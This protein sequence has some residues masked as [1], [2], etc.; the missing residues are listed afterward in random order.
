MSATPDPVELSAPR[1]PAR[2]GRTG[3]GGP[4]GWAI[5]AFGVL[6]VLAGAAIAHFGPELLPAR[7]IHGSAPEPGEALES[8]PPPASFV[9]APPAPP[10]GP[11]QTPPSVGG[12]DVAALSDRLAALEAEA[13][14]T[15]RAAAAALAAAALVEAAQTSR[16]FGEELSALERA[17]GPSLDLSSLD[18]LAQVGAPSRAALSAAFPDY[19]ARAV[20]AS[21]RP[22]DGAGLLDRIG[23]ALSRVVTLRRVGET[24]GSGVDAVLARAERQIE[25][26]DLDAALRTLD[27]LPAPSREAV[28]AWRAR[29]ERRAE[30]DRRVAAI[31][32]EALRTLAEPAGTP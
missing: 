31:R 5:A 23:Y 16:P 22:L 25:D 29:A 13:D 3:R 12:Q 14:A 20:S 9:L 4:G 21:R 2:Y 7:P 30:I 17:A 11:V 19:A 24:S 8:A 1:D 32:A 15:R 18:R 27:G 10:A 28:A 6:C 26:G